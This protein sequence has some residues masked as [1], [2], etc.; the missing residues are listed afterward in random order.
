MLPLFV[1]LNYREARHVRGEG[2]DLVSPQKLLWR[3]LPCCI[4]A[5]Q[6]TL[7]STRTQLRVHK[8]FL[9][10]ALLPAQLLFT[11]EPGG[12]SSA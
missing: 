2:W 6:Y 11:V 7:L 4:S 3:S 8:A 10:A 12:R 9:L 5:L 1:V